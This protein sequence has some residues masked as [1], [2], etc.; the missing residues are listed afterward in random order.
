LVPKLREVSLY[1]GYVFQPR[2]PVTN[3]WNIV[4][5]TFLGPRQRPKRNWLLGAE[6]T[7][8]DRSFQRSRNQCDRNSLYCDLCGLRQGTLLNFCSYNYFF[9]SARQ[10]NTRK[11]FKTRST[12]LL[13]KRNSIKMRWECVL[14]SMEFHVDLAC[15]FGTLNAIKLSA[16]LPWTQRPNVTHSST[17]SVP[18][19]G[20]CN[21]GIEV[22]GR[23]SSFHG[24]KS[25]I[26]CIKL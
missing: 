22:F 7:H 9:R 24:R 21:N 5:F 6:C 16:R 18:K 26:H 23:V 14:N 4:I 1:G 11:P 19:N 15:I 10:A 12:T 3:I 17:T 13:Q 8:L 20:Q 25:S 2:K